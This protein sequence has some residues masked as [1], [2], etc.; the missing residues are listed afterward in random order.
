MTL[1]FQTRFQESGGC[2][3]R[4][5]DLRSRGQS[6]SQIAMSYIKLDRYISVLLNYPNSKDLVIKRPKTATGV[7]APPP[8]HMMLPEEV[9]PDNNCLTKEMT[10]QQELAG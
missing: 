8:Y 7:K 9:I 10:R 2:R 3:L 1:Q 5:N 4:P 6:Q